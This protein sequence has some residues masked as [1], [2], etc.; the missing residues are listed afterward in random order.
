MHGHGLGVV[1]P[2]V[3]PTLVEDFWARG[4]SCRP[5]Q[6]WG[7]LL[8]LSPPLLMVTRDLAEGKALLC[9]GTCFQGDTARGRGWCMA[10]G[11]LCWWGPPAGFGV[12]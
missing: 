4:W 1:G 12:Q 5:E 9:L 2:T 6:V 8:G 3:H 11:C 10:S 7:G